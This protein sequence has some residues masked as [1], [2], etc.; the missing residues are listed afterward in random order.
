MAGLNRYT[1]KIFGLTAGTNE[2]SEYGSAIASPPGNL[3]SGA[4]ITPDII[5]QLSQYSLGLIGALG[6]AY[7]P[8]LEDQNS[9]FRLITQQLA[10]IFTRGIPEWDSG[11]TYNTNDF[12][13]VGNVQYYSL[14]DSNTNNDPTSSPSDWRSNSTTPTQ[15]IL[16]SSGTYTTPSLRP[17]F[18]HVR[19]NGPGGGGAG[20]GS[21]L[22]GGN[23]GNG[24][25][26]S[27]GSL[28]IANGGEGALGGSSLTPGNGGTASIAVG[29]I[30][31]IINGQNGGMGIIASPGSTN[32][33]FQLVGGNGGQSYLGGGGQGGGVS[34]PASSG[35]L[36]SG[37]GGGGGGGLLEAGID[38]AC[39]P[40]GG[41]G[42][43]VDAIIPNPAPSY[44][45]LIGLP[46]AGGNAGGFINNRPGA[47]GS[48]SRIIVTE[49]YQ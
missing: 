48:D 16:T 6:G 1:Q 14:I 13:K 36:N 34:T 18:L 35:V 47:N 37:G 22:D 29:A 15:Q 11:T 23:G 19:M 2:M 41:A 24:G 33:G 42:A 27:F 26:T 45:F 12:C 5:Q 10:Y 3:Y 17:L 32:I 44:P 25:N 4:T 49:Y 20:S 28:L 7:S 40:G 43:Y 46:G 31:Y 39:G 30:G 8:P 38:M 9:L 21:S